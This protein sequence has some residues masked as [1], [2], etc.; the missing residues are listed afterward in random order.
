MKLMPSSKA[1]STQAAA[2]SRDAAR[3]G[4]P[5]TEADLRHLE[6]LDP[7]LRSLIA[8]TLPCLVGCPRSILHC[9]SPRSRLAVANLPASVE[10][11]SRVMGLPV[12]E[13]DG[14]RAS[15]GAAGETGTRA[16]GAREPAADPATAAPA[17][18][19]SPGCIRPARRSPIRFAASASR[20]GP[21]RARPITRSPRRC[22]WTTPTGSASR[23]TP[24]G[25]ASSGSGSPTAAACGW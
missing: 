15:L 8:A 16:D 21:S 13:N 18:S 5:R 11:Y 6:S 22:T 20:G 24:T 1:A 2:C 19:T 4:Q 14:R 9:E 3:V 10:F 23:S 25:R 7:S 17:C 12:L